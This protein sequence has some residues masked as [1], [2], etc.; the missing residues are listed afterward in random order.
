MD[1]VNNHIKESRLIIAHF[2]KWF[3][4]SLISGISVGLVITLFLKSLEYVTQTRQIYAWL[5]YLLPVGGYIIS[6]LYYKYGKDSSKGNNLII[7]RINNGKGRIPFRM[8]PLVFLGTVA[9]HLFGG[10][11]GR[12]G[13]GVQIGASICSEL[14]ELLKLDES[15]KNL[16]IISGISSGFG[17]VF[18][19]P[20]S[21]TVFGLEVTSI[22]KMR[23]E[24]IVPCFVASYIGNSIS[25]I[26][27]VHHMNYSMVG[28][29]DDVSIFYKVTL[30]SILFGITSKVFSELTHILK[31]YFSYHIRMP[32][33]RSFL[34]GVI[35]IVLVFIVNSR[36]YLGLSLDL[37]KYS[38]EIPVNNYDFI[39]KL[40]FT[41]ITLG[42]GYQGGE[43][44]PLF[45]IG[46][47]L[48][49]TLSFMI[50]LPMSFLAGLGMIGVFCG[51]TKTPIA[52][53]IMGVE[54]FG[55]M[56][57]KYLFVACVISYVFAGKSGI[58]TSQEYNI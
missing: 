16:I 20:I 46:A 56:N 17:V 27:K 55:S 9:T 15:D 44:T 53:F 34:G 3:F 19:T 1:F 6:F 32:Y 5:L 39:L 57:M 30:C 54:L 49:N 41:S 40:I 31:K 7:E 28:V 36:I 48:G 18:G 45:V 47:T 10:S 29:I 42:S 11:A 2:I 13:T 52:S 43:V 23:Y 22:G 51:A 25:N 37:L 24:A 26:L 14:G 38:F 58:Y 21:G 8:A 50:G 35:I 33:N 12:E 4:L